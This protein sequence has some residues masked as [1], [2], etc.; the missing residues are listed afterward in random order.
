MLRAFEK[1]NFSVFGIDLSKE[2]K[3][4]CKPIDVQNINLEDEDF[5]YKEKNFVRNIARLKVLYMSLFWFALLTN[6]T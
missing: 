1:N 6:L 2:A 5:N 4:M 3:E